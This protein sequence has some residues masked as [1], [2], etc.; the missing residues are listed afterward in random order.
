MFF[1]TALEHSLTS[2]VMVNN[3]GGTTETTGTWAIEEV[4]IEF[5]GWCSVQFKI[6]TLTQIK[7]LITE[8][9]VSLK[10]MSPAEINRTP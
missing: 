3:I 7:T 2:E 4:A 6:W 1:L 8:G 10:P 5:A 9:S